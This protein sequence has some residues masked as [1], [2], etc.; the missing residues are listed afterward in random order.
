[1]MIELM[2]SAMLSAIMKVI[3]GDLVM[4]EG[5]VGT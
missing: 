5:K 3:T 1:V 4:A 2:V